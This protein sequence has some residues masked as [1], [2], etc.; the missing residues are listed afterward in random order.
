MVLLIKSYKY[1]L[2]IYYMLGTILSVEETTEDLRSFPLSV[3]FILVIKTDSNR[4]SKHRYSDGNQCY[5][6]EKL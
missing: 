1:L 2:S 5:E 6:D 4:K 3:S